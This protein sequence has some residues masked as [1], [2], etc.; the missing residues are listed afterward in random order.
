MNKSALTIL[1]ACA[2]LGAVSFAQDP[3]FMQKLDPKKHRELMPRHARMMEEQKKQDAELEPLLA[4]M[5]DATGE[6]RVDALI[7]VVHKLIEQRK[8]MQEKIA[9]FLDR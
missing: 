8:A 6:K 2:L 5:N 3:G 4:A 7:V 9:G 1:T